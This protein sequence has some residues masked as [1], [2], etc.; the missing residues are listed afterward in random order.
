MVQQL[1]GPYRKTDHEQKDDKTRME[2]NVEKELE[3]NYGLNL[4]EKDLSAF[5][6]P[7]PNL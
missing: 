5:A 3:G 1:R 6:F 4:Y 7:S 2:P